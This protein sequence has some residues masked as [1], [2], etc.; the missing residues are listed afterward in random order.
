MWSGSPSGTSRKGVIIT[1]DYSELPD[2]LSIKRRVFSFNL[3]RRKNSVD[4][5]YHNP[6]VFNV[7]DLNR[8]PA[9]KLVRRNFA[10]ML[11]KLR[12]KLGLSLEQASLLSG[13]SAG[14]ITD[15]ERNA[16]KVNFKDWLILLEK[17]SA[18]E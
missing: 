15:I 4:I 3:M 6:D 9:E 2:R 18:M 5:H 10:A 8:S 12:H 11:A 17:Y 1:S 16:G 13:L 7:L 14:E